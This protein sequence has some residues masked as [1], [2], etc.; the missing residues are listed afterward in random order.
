M[1]GRE[2]LHREYTSRKRFTVVPR[3]V[4]IFHD[5]VIVSKIFFCSGHKKL[6]ILSLQYF[7]TSS[8]YQWIFYVLQ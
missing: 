7:T 4:M 8:S 6:Q 1:V 5:K 2:T 3:S